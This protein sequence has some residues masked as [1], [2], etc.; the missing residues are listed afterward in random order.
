MSSE[1]SLSMIFLP[2]MSVQ[3]EFVPHTRRALQMDEIYVFASSFLWLAYQFFDLHLAGLTGN[4]WLIPVAVLP[5]A[6]VLVGPGT[7]F[8]VGW[9]WRES[10]LERKRS[11]E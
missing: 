1:Y 2:D 10:I 4:D 7:A 5:V 11:M 3:S 9:F 8:T 6:S